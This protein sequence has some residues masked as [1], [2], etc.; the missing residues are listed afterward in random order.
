MYDV[1]YSYHKAR[2]K[3][4][5][6]IVRKIHVQNV[7]YL[8]KTNPHMNGCAQFEGQLYIPSSVTKDWMYTTHGLFN[9]IYTPLGQKG[10]FIPES[11]TQQNPVY[12]PSL[13]HSVLCQ[14]FKSLILLCLHLRARLLHG[15][16]H[17]TQ[18]AWEGTLAPWS[19]AG[20]FSRNGWTVNTAGSTGH[21][22]AHNHSG[23]SSWPE[24]SL[25]QYV[26]SRARLRSS[27]ILLMDIKMRISYKFVT[28]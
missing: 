16:A 7:L 9:S 25:E 14:M 3:H 27:E 21:T 20:A 13:F 18:T 8:S 1:L 24:S 26:H 6:G 2:K 12:L 5:K 28:E 10:L 4:I 17:I 22:L 11:G 15:R 23:L 19:W